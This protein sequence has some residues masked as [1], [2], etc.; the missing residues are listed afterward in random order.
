MNASLQRLFQT[1]HSD[2]VGAPPHQSMA[3]R[4]ARLYKIK[5]LSNHTRDALANGQ[6]DERCK[7]V[8]NGG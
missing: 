8:I 7:R 5:C 6:Q 3:S 2:P 4:L 1:V